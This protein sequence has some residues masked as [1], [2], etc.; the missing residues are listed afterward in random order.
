[1]TEKLLEASSSEIHLIEEECPLDGA[2]D[3]K[4]MFAVEQRERLSVF[5][6]QLFS[7]HWVPEAEEQIFE[8]NEGRFHQPLYHH[9]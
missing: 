9:E 5:L 2:K 3:L 6:L 8:I 1:L 4:T 7:E